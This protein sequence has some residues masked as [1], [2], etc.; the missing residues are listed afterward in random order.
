L[1]FA[2]AAH[3]T[4]VV[5]T[6]EPTAITDA[7][8]VIKTAHRQRPDLDA[9]LIVNQAGDPDEGLHVYTRV[10]NVCR[11]FLR[12]DLPYAGCLLRDPIVSQSV[13]LRRPF[14]LDAK[15]SPAAVALSALAHRLDKHA[16]EPQAERTGLIKRMT[17]R[18][19]RG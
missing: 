4:L 9:R 6:P 8:A 15:Q 10:A 1:A 3:T 17:A 13:R 2:A 19:V 5:T 7:Y 14:A 11:K 18:L 12:L 16:A